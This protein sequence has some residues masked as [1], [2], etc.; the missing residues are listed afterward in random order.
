MEI[1]TTR[2]DHTP[3]KTENARLRATAEEFEAVFL[4]VMLS[5]AFQG[6]HDEGYLDG[7][8]TETWRDMQIEHMSQSIAENGGLGISDS[9]YQELLRM[10][11]ASGT[12]A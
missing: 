1:A 7:K 11:E 8:S 5:S 6:L 10:Q 12:N 9:I 2:V 4:K 3:I